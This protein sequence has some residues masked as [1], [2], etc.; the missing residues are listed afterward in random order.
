MIYVMMVLLI[1]TDISLCK[2]IFKKAIKPKA[3]VYFMPVLYLVGG[4][5]ILA[6]YLSVGKLTSGVFYP[7]F[8]SLTFMWSYNM[9]IIQLKHIIAQKYKIFNNATNLL[10]GTVLVFAVAGKYLPCSPAQFFTVCA[11][12]QGLVFLEFCSSVLR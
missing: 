6:F 10:I 2:N 1:L 5:S 4:L 12:L 3:E 8:Y 11:I 9:I 7:F